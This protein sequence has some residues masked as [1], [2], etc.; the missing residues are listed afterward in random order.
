MVNANGMIIKLGHTIVSYMNRIA[1]L[2]I[3]PEA[4]FRSD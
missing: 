1:T 4:I 3:V 2:R